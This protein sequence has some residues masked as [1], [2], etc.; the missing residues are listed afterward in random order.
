V[1]LACIYYL[2]KNPEGFGTLV[3]SYWMQSVLLGL[4]NFVNMLSVKKVEPGSL[5]MNNKPVTESKASKGC[6]ALFFL[7][8]YNAFHLAYLVFII[9][10]YFMSID[11]KYL[12]LASGGF[13]LS[14]L[15][16]FI[17]NRS[18]GNNTPANMGKMM[19]LPYVRIIPMHLVILAPQFLNITAPML[20][21][22]LK[23]FADV[24]MYLF[25]RK[26]VTTHPYRQF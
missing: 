14:L 7:V 10:T 20:F 22:W 9:V 8:H 4:F 12:M 11:F 3:M 5:T 24:I 15:I 16:E 1:N 6:A 19:F 2:D 17:Q 25:S 18:E 23:T 21:L 13:A 26:A